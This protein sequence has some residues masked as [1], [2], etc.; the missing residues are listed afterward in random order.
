MTGQG[1]VAPP[2]A[3][4][5]PAPAT[6]AARAVYP[7]AAIFDGHAAEITSAGLSSG[8]IGL[9]QVTLRVPAV[10]AAGFHGLSV[11]VNGVTSNTVLIELAGD[12]SPTRV[13]RRRK[14]E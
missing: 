11:T 9:F 4:G 10:A 6:P 14:R 3:T 12:A 13:A 8:S 5:S 2:I 1:A 7:I